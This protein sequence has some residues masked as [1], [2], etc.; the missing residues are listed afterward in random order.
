ML[1]LNTEALTVNKISV[2]EQLTYMNKAFMIVLQGAHCAT[3]DMP[4]FSQLIFSRR[5]RQ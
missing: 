3:A 2:I 4:N 1:Q 5:R